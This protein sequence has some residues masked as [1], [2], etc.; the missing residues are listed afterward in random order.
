MHNSM[1][2]AFGIVFTLLATDTVNAAMPTHPEIDNS[3]M[4]LPDGR[5]LKKISVKGKKLELARGGNIKFGLAEQN[6]YLKLKQETLTIPGHLVQ[7]TLMDLDRHQV[8]AQSASARLK[9]FGASVAK[10]F[11]AATL[12]DKK[13]GKLSKSQLQLMADMLVVSSNTAWTELQKQIGD[14]YDDRGRATTH[15]FTQRMGYLRTRGF[16]GYWGDMHGNELTTEELAE[17]LYD[18]YQGNYPGAEVQWKIMHTCRTG[19]SR[20][21][22]YLPSSLYIGGKTGTYDGSTVNPETGST[23]NANGT[24]YSVRVRN[25]VVV[26]NV[27]GKEYGLAILADTGSDESAALLAGGLLHEYTRY[28]K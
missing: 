11:T 26:F 27:K 7:W 6:A 22:K 18:T 25:H 12:L 21:R 19:E 4:T 3:F 1:Q 23:Q 28:E 13:N 14:G 8:I 2:I 16:Q 9:I 10:I 17:F 5:S 15:A 20:A 24:Q